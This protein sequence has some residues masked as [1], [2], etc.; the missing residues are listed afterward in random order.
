MTVSV[1]TANMESFL[2]PVRRNGHIPG[3]AGIWV[4]I[5]CEFVE[6]A[7][8]FIVYFVARLHYP[9]AF[10]EGPEGLSRSAGKIGRAHV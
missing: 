6:F 5:T 2:P 10:H 4:G 9:E 8:L 1:E 7:V 3:N